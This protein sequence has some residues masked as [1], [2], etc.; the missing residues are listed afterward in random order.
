MKVIH[1]L[2]KIE[3]LIYE[4]WLITEDENYLEILAHLSHLRQ[5]MYGFLDKAEQ[6]HEESCLNHPSN[7]PK[8]QIH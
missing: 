7:F 6:E 2:G 3:A 8:M 4:N 1:N 5:E